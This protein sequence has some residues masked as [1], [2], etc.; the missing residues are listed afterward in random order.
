MTGEAAPAIDHDVDVSR[1]VL[2]EIAHERRRRNRERRGVQNGE[3]RFL[4]RS[5][6]VQKFGRASGGSSFKRGM[7]GDPQGKRTERRLAC[8]INHQETGRG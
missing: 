6:A 3:K 8:S 7:A 5:V 4:D 1:L 2:F